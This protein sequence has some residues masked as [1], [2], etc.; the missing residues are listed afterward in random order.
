VEDAESKREELSLAAG[1]VMRF[2]LGLLFHVVSFFDPQQDPGIRVY[3]PSC[4]N[5]Q[6]RLRVGRVNGNERSVTIL[7]GAGFSQRVRETG[8]PRGGP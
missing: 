4:E 8:K 1:W 6:G 7:A 5:C 3:V 2:L